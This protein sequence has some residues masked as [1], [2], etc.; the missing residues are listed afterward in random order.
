MAKKICFPGYIVLAM[1]F[2]M[3]CLL[4]EHFLEKEKQQEIV[5]NFSTKNIQFEDILYEDDVW[6]CYENRILKK[7]NYDMKNIQQIVAMTNG[8]LG[9]CCG[10]SRIYVLPVPSAIA[11]E[12]ENNKESYAE[13]VGEISKNLPEQC[14]LVDV[15]PGLES[16]REEYIFF[17]T[18]DSWTARGAYYGMDAFCEKIGVEPIALELYEEHV[19]NSFYGSLKSEYIS[20]EC[21][22]RIVYYS[23]PDSKN[24]AQICGIQEDGER[25]CYKKPLVTTSAM[26]TGSFLDNHFCRAIVEGEARN[27]IKKGKYVLV[28]CDERGKLL[29]PYL[30]D[31]YDG[32]YVVNIMED[33]DF[34]NDLKDIIKRYD[35]SEV[36]YA[37]SAVYMGNT[38]FSRAL[39]GFCQTE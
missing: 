7:C 35:I 11:L 9:K 24:R 27:D 39:N 32:V 26:N 16:H 6:I 19:Y 30:K 2:C 31:Y 25:Y 15:M 33:Y 38:G 3:A 17:N 5:H 28:V 8:M 37:Q 1:C 10:I 20:S 14:V 12:D 29:V 4:L 36:V 13:Y 21:E 22:D 34:K 18:E 23:L